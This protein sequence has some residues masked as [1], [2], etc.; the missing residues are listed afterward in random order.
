MRLVATAAA[1]ESHRSVFKGERPA[2]VAVA[3]EAIGLIGSEHR[4]HRRPHAAVRI[5][6]IDAAHRAFRQS[7]VLRLL[8][9][10]P[11]IL[12]TSGALRIDLARLADYQAI[13]PVGVNLVAGHAGNRTVGMAALQ[14]ARVRRLIEM[15]G[16]AD[17]VGCCRR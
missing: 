12:V 13:R 1:L 15:A 9:L 4:L 3:A 17:L 10:R 16:Q 8:E 2:L 11:D 7:M 5:V 14:A 6:A